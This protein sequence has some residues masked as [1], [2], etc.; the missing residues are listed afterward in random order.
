MYENPNKNTDKSLAV[1]DVIQL[2]RLGIIVT[3]PL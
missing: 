3:L 1:F 2:K